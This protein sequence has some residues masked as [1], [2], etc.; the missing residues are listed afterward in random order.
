MMH[1]QKNIKFPNLFPPIKVCG[2]YDVRSGYI[3]LCQFQ[4]VITSSDWTC[5]AVHNLYPVASPHLLFHL[6]NIN[7]RPKLLALCVTKLSTLGY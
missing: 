1:G 6:S 4:K 5:D 7:I 2:F 3:V